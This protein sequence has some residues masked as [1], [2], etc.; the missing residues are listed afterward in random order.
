[1]LPYTIV[2]NLALCL[3]LLT[4]AQTSH[5]GSNIAVPVKAQQH[6]AAADNAGTAAVRLVKTIQDK[7]NQ[8]QMHTLHT[9]HVST[10][11]YWPTPP[12]CLRRHGC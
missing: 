9:P 8:H 3:L 12:S 11:Q 1:M 6:A 4:C 10:S 2:R 5:G 7:N